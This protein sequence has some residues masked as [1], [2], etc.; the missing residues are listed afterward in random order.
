MCIQTNRITS[1]L[2]ACAA[3]GL[4][5]IAMPSPAAADKRPPIQGAPRASVLAAC[6]KTQGC[7]YSTNAG[8]VTVG[9]SGDNCFACSKTRCV[10]T[11][12]KQQP[13]GHVPVGQVNASPTRAAAASTGPVLHGGYTNPTGPTAPTTIVHRKH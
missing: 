6:D 12:A 8:G 2:V 1:S 10:P 13:G 7:H 5:F 11:V 4:A 3:M 9:C